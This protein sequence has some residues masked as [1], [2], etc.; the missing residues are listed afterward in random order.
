MVELQDEKQ[1]EET[2]EKVIL[3]RIT[4]VYG[5]K[6]WVKVFSYTDPMEAIVD[7]SPWFIR[8]ENRKSS[9]WSRVKLKAGKRHAKTVVAKLENCNDRDEAMTYVGTEIAIELRQLEELKEKNEYYWRDLIGLRVIN[10]QGIELGVVKS[11]METGANDVLVVVSDKEA[12]EG[13]SKET[14]ERLIPWTMDIAIIKVDLE[15]GVI[16]VDWDAD[17]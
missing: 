1:Q 10:Q 11:L 12:A 14:I 6:G 17:F 15:Q 13:D 5:V 9:A 2:S 3:G 7:Y 16:T 8:A 4:G